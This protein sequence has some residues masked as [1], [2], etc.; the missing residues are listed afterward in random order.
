M[1]AAKLSGLPATATRLKPPATGEET[2]PPFTVFTASRVAY[3]VE[4]LSAVW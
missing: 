1:I 4:T 2:R 3:D